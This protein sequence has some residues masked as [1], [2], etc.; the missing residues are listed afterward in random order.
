MKKET[1]FILRGDIVYS[2]APLEIVVNEDSYLVCMNG[3]VEGVYTSIPK[4]FYKL[5]LYNYEGCLI[6]PG[7]ADLHLH[8]PQYSF[9][10]LNMDLEL[11][12]WLEQVAFPEESK[13]SELIYANEAYDYFVEDLKKSATTRACVFATL[14]PQST[15]LLMEKLEKTGLHCMVGKVNMD[16]NSPDYLVEGTKD[17]ITRTKKWITSVKDKYQ[18][19]IPIIT[20]RFLPSCTDE[21]M[22]ELGNICREYQL[23]LQSHLSENK[24]EIKWVKELFPSADSYSAAYEQLGTFGGDIHTV[25]AHCLYID[26][27]EMDLMKKNGVYMAHCPSS[28]TNILSG[29]APLRTYLDYKIQIGLGSDIGAG[30]NLSLFNVMAE[31][32]KVSKL[33]TCLVKAE[34]KPITSR[35]AF[36]LATKGGGSF[37]GKVGSF[38]VGYELDAIIIKDYSQGQPR[39]F[40]VEER[41][42]RLIY[43][44]KE[45]DIVAKYC[46]GTQIFDCYKSNSLL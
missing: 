16:R 45:N 2:K 1:S 32:I 6:I 30:D 42:E 28:N 36:Y 8:A 44:A 35:E 5:R 27:Y 15:I 31:A 17:S 22:I 29:I 37:F 38:E 25:M 33:Y 40:Q 4:E 3:E 10:G 34:L 39:D 18:N 23:P 7:M 11:I 24:G 41:L 46:K 26:K 12:Q 19:V 9:R 13:Y 20:P 14:H 43:S 21:L